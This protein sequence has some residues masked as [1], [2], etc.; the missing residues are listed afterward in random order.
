VQVKL[1]E[2][3]SQSDEEPHGIAPDQIG[4]NA[5][6]DHRSGMVSRILSLMLYLPIAR[7]LLHFRKQLKTLKRISGWKLWWRRIESLSKNKLGS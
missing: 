6:K 2:F 7:I 3:E 1:D 5:T 4:L